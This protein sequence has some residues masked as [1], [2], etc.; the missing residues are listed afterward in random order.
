M[1]RTLTLFDDMVK[2]MEDLFGFH[3]TYDR[4]RKPV[5]TA[6]IETPGVDR[7]DINIEV[8]DNF[9]RVNWKNRFGS[10]QS[11]NYWIDDAE[12]IDAIYKDGLLKITVKHKKQ[13]SKSKRI[14]LKGG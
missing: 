9:L 2:D 6:E 7:K 10:S 3:Y 11:R 1:T 8:K 4:P 13:E 14:E 5:E 12:D